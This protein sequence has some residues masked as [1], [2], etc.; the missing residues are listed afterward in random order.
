MENLLITGT[1]TFD[2][3]DPLKPAGKYVFQ[4]VAPGKGN[5]P[6]HPAFDLQLR[7]HVIPFDPM[8]PAQLARRALLAAAVARWHATAP[9][10]RQ[11][12]AGIAKQR[13]ISLFNASVSDYL[14]NPP[15]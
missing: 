4:R 3:P 1:L 13:K 2:P 11:Q 8:T 15:T 14:K 6:G 5:L 12:W 10:E 9:A 7:R